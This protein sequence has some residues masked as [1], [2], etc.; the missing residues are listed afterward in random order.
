MNSTAVKVNML[1]SYIQYWLL[2]VESDE[3][4][5]AMPEEWLVEL[6]AVETLPI[7]V[8]TEG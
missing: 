5:D 4:G 8:R 1:I 2:I 3:S 7:D 6:R